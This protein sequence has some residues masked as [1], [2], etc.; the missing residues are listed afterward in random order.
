MIFYCVV[1]NFLWFI[2]H[3]AIRLGFQCLDR[4]ATGDTYTLAIMAYAYS[5]YDSGSPVRQQIMN[6][7]ERRKISGNSVKVHGYTP[8]GRSL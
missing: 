3:P 2:Q 6:E 8:K 7:L 5:L 4:H 1:N